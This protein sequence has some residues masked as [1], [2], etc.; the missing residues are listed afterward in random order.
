MGPLTALVLHLENVRMIMQTHSVVRTIV[1]K[2]LTY[3]PHSDQIL[4]L[5]TISSYLYFNFAPTLI[6]RDSYPRRKEI[7]VAFA[8]TCFSEM[9]CII[10]LTSFIF[11]KCYM[12]T[13]RF[14]N[15]EGLDWSYFLLSIFHNF[16]CGW[17]TAIFVFYVL[18][19]S[20]YNGM[21]ELT[22]FADRQFYMDWWT[23]RNYGEFY[24]KWH[25]PV[26]DWLYTYIYKDIKN[27][28][29]SKNP[30]FPRIMPRQQFLASSGLNSGKRMN[31]QGGG[32]ISTKVRKIELARLQS[33]YYSTT[34][35][36]EQSDDVTFSGYK[37]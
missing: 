3:K 28:I 31:A 7:N 24:R 20:W 37:L 33:R 16:L 36:S 8:L 5:P 10:W 6:Y 15:L 4:A 12:N 23:S 9:F 29:T 17:Y 2:V 13:S 14:C 11:E 32:I 34:I 19:Q 27:T 26:Q 25:V 30:Y 1:P 22:K 21:A 18:L 35:F